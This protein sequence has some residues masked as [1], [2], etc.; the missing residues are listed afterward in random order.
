MKRTA[1]L[2]A[3]KILLE[4]LFLLLAAIA[5][6]H[7]P[8]AISNAIGPDGCPG[9]PIQPTRI[10]TGQFGVD[11]Q[12]S[13]VMVP[14]E[15]PDGTTA[16]RVKYCWDDP[17]GGSQRHTIDLGLWDARPANETWGPKQFR[18]WGGSSHP[19]VTVSR[20]G[21]SSEA[22]YLARPRGHVPGRTTRG[23]IP[24]RLRPGIWAAELGVG[25]VVTQAD[26]DADGTVRWR[27]EIELSRDR[28]FDAD[29][30][31]P[32]RFDGRAARREPGWYAG[33][34]HVHAEHSALGDATMS[35]VFDYAFRRLA[36]GGAGLDFLMLSDYV[37]RSAW[38]EIG[39]Y[40]QR[41]PGKLVARSTEIIT[42]QGHANNHVSVQY[43][44]HRTGPV[45]ERA[46]DGALTLLRAASTPAEIFREVHR[47]GGFTQINHPTIFP[48]SVPGFRLFCRGCPWDY[49]A[50]ETGFESV[51]AIEI[52]T[53][54]TDIGG[55]LNPFTRE[56]IAFWERALA[57]GAHVA[58]VGS[59]DSH[60]AGRTENAAQS[61]VGK[62]ATVLYARRLSE[63]EIRRA[64]QEGHTYVKLLGNAGPDVRLEGR[65]GKRRAIMGDTLRGG[66]AE[67]TVQVLNASVSSQPRTL[68]VVKD[69]EPFRQFAVTAESATFAFA[70]DGPG[71]Y[72]LQLERGPLIEAV[73][74]PI[75]LEP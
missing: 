35:E 58:A 73:S 2:Q 15:V 33:D 16:V 5:S 46:P 56:A 31:R 23:F 6:A 53:G 9:D 10:M 70:A 22:E 20:Q 1:T 17:E 74:S 45:Y 40:Q 71:R 34:M 57:T 60:R 66:V 32:A 44:D 14:F 54:P 72:R 18:G 52:Q 3:V 27:V 43:V 65:A 49:D 8:L 13:Y 39:R 67:F 19:D 7:E 61:P 24:G 29:R 38:G 51:D 37:S 50:A 48:S 68:F 36:D 59:S 41:F 55:R 63:H 25:G 28:A 75:Y 12:G 69:G 42:Y 30:Y 4:A 62:P 26:G 11:L 64:V 47:A 21:F